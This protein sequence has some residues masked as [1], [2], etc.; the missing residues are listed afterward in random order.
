MTISEGFVKVKSL[1]KQM[2]KMTGV[3]FVFLCRSS[4]FASC[5]LNTV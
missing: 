2:S 1:G 3:H 5:A 4:L